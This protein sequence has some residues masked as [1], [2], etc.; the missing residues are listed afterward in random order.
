[1]D[2]EGDAERSG[3]TRG[4]EGAGGGASEFAA[5]RILGFGTVEGE[6]PAGE[7][8]MLFIDPPAIGQG[9]GSALLSYL[10]AIA[11]DL[12]FHRLTIAADPNAEPF[13]L[14]KGAVR[15]GGVPSGSVPGRVLPLLALAL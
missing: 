3:G 12:G 14:A 9:V 2:V 1:V 6:P 11:T 5:G 8:G 7:L 13:Y 10:A 15:I 4:R